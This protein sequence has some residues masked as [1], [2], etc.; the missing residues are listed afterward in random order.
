MS[1]TKLLG[2]I[3]EPEIDLS[4]LNGEDA[5]GAVASHL[6][7][8]THGINSDPVTLFG[9]VYSALIHDVDHYGVGNAQTIKENEALG[10]KYKGKSVAEQNS[11][12][13]AWDL[14]CSDDLQELR[15]YLFNG[16]ESE[17]LRL[18][19]VVVNVVCKFCPDIKSSNHRRFL[20]LTTL[21][22]ISGN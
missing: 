1:A 11:F 5:H 15:A 10:T 2:R 20:V 8:Y 16:D 12:D 19:Q 17:M 13:I 22:S 6:H 14:L 3:V 9:I 21:F 4:V 7:D 18:R